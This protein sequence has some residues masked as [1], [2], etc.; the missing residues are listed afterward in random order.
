M[1]HDPLISI[2]NDNID[3]RIYQ[4]T[5]HFHT[6]GTNRIFDDIVPFNTITT[7]LTTEQIRLLQSSE[8]SFS[9][10]CIEVKTRKPNDY[11][12]RQASVTEF[13]S[14][15]PSLP[16]D[17]FFT[18]IKQSFGLNDDK[19]NK[20]MNY[21]SGG[22]FYSGQVVIYVKNV[23]DLLSGA[24]HY[25]PFSNKL[26]R[27]NTLSDESVNKALFIKQ[28]SEFMHYDFFIYYGS[29]L[30]KHIC[31]YGYRGYRL[32]IMEIGSMYRNLEISTSLFNLQSRVWGGFNDEAL[33]VAL[34]IDPRVI[35][36]MI[37]QLVGKQ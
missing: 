28:A 7:L 22:A 9:G 33:S 26:E 23:A 20:I 24:Y 2:I 12:R 18:I 4:D 36:P 21:P 5:I 32:A 16:K 10:D 34:G 6:K 15:R 31:K 3:Q 14:H 19:K 17:I 25:L 11:V 13:S 30:S 37:C 27:L 29:L 8:H 1:M 35:L